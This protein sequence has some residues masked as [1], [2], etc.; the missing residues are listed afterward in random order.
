MW[1]QT[2]CE[3]ETKLGEEKKKK[4]KRIE[5]SFDSLQKPTNTNL[6]ILNQPN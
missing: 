2:E 6:G 1:L 4:C 3:I 5:T